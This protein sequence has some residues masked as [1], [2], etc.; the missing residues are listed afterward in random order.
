MTYLTQ[1]LR[2]EKT[3]LNL[4]D[5]LWLGAE[6]WPATGVLLQSPGEE[7]AL[8]MGRR[9]LCSREGFSC[10]VKLAARC[11]DDELLVIPGIL[12]EKIGGWLP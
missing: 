12:A 5:G 4:I 7:H 10:Q 1:L 3:N 2:A 6:S 9:K 11:R 8:Q